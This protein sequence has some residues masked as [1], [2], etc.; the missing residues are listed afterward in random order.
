MTDK[1]FNVLKG[2]IDRIVKWWIKQSGL[3]WWRVAVEYER[4]D[5]ELDATGK[6]ALAAET[7]AKWQYLDATIIFNMRALTERSLDDLE[8]TIV[9]ELM[10]IFVNEMRERGLLHEERVATSLAK[11][12]I[13]IRDAGKELGRQEI[14]KEQRQLLKP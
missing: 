9:H 10:H 6:Y 2:K 8:G 14:K 13:W 3:G 11:G 4:E 7:T 1:E 12:F 5:K